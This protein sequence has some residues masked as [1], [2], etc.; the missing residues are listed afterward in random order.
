R[1]NV[2]LLW[3]HRSAGRKGSCRKSASGKVRSMAVRPF[4]PATQQMPFKAL[5]DRV[6]KTRWGTWVAINIGQRIDPYLMRV[7]RGRVRISFTAPTILLTQTG[8]K[9]GKRR[10]TPLLYFTH[11]ANVVLIASKGGAPHH[12]AVQDRQRGGE[13]DSRWRM[14]TL[15]IDPHRLDGRGI[16]ETHPLVERSR[17]PNGEKDLLVKVRVALFQALHDSATDTGAL[18][19]RENKQMGVVDDQCPVRNGIPEPDQ[20]PLMPGRDDCLGLAE[21]LEKLLWLA[22]R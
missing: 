7:T 20:R 19:R 11:G 21:R 10:T 2:R 22:R 16:G 3:A 4:D 12:P 17:V 9:T 1:V 14:I 15:V 8:A 13:A 6:F 18:I 5:L